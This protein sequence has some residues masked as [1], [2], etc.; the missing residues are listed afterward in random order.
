M[1][2]SESYFP[3]GKSIISG[4]PI[5]RELLAAAAANFT[6][7]PDKT[8]LLVLGGSQGAHRVNL[9][10]PAAMAAIKKQRLTLPAGFEIIHQ[11]GEKDEKQTRAAYA[12]L[13]IKARVTPFINDMAEAYNR[14][15]LVISRAGATTLAE[16]ALF[17]KPVIL[18]PFPYAADNHQEKNGDLFVGN[19]GAKMF[20]E[21]EL[22]GEKLG[23]QIINLLTKPKL[24][25]DMAAQNGRLAAPKAAEIILNECLT[26]V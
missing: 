2:G 24:L 6:R 20:R 21:T 12:D 9:L 3:A 26:Y 13:D 22:S 16:L 17:K 5:R 4:N 11:T 23:R 7:P 15:D 18:I 25:G 14:A 10:L 8:T 19:G 1:P